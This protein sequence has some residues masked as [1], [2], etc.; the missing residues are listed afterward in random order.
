MNIIGFSGEPS[1]SGVAVATFGVKVGLGIEVATCN[2]SSVEGGAV[3]GT[4]PHPE[5]TSR[6]KNHTTL[7][8]RLILTLQNH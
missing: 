2:G 4:G 8:V 1:K 7:N 5:K 6:A 3:A